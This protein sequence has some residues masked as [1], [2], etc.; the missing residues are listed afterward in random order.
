MMKGIRGITLIALVITII[1]LLILAGVSIAMLTGDNGILTQANESKEENLIG[2]EK[3]QIKLAIQSLRIN[4]EVNNDST[5]LTTEGLQK[6]MEIEAGKEKTE[7]LTAGDEYEVLF[8]ETNRYYIIDKEGN[9][10]GVQKMIKDKNPGDITKGKNGE[11]LDGSEKHPY[12]IWNIEDLVVLSNMTNGQGVKIENGSIVEI[13]SINNFSEKYIEL[14]RNLNFKSKLSYENSERTDF[15]DIND[16]VEDGN[17]LIKEM[18]TGRGFI[19]IGKSY[20][21]SFWGN[22][23]GNN[24][25]I[26]NIYITSTD[27]TGLFGYVESVKISNLGIDGK[28]TGQAKGIGG[29]IGAIWANK[30]LKTTIIEN[31]YNKAEV[32]GKLEGD[33]TGTG[34][35]IGSV[36]GKTDIINCYNEGN[37]ASEQS[38]KS[39]QGS[40]GI[41]GYIRGPIVNIFNSYNIG[42]ISSNKK[43]S[44]GIVGE[45]WGEGNLNMENVFN[46][47]ISD[48]GIL[49]AK[50]TQNVTGKSLYYLDNIKDEG[51]QEAETISK[52]QLCSKDF[53]NKLNDYINKENKFTWKK[54]TFR[55]N[56][57]PTFE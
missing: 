47:G 41:V 52:E 30:E 14:K 45:I 18:E 44:S 24:F 48:K 50:V 26:K 25:E 6:Q 53:V 32:N 19:P 21:T 28:I 22:F 51:D 13:S 27:Y 10:I 40:G 54:W 16:N 55:K 12:E 4:K 49:G 36:S 15:G 1:V 29:L 35:I 37:I 3:E 11:R 39:G 31:C 23:E 46:A 56:K 8:K 42:N 7:V 5:I 43:E 34:G 20:A 9:I 17:I 2:K 38:M 57:Y 33:Y